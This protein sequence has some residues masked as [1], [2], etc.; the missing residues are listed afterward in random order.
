MQQFIFDVMNGPVVEFSER[1][2]FPDL[3]AAR[4][5]AGQLAD[6]AHAMGCD[7]EGWRVELCNA[8]DRV[9]DTVQVMDCRTRPL[10]KARSRPAPPIGRGRQGQ[11]RKTTASSS[12]HHDQPSLV[13]R[14]PGPLNSCAVERRSLR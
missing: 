5:Y 4:V 6:S 10:S 14:R 7:V 13:A 12:G 11:T 3:A 2:A 8:E 9:I 1:Q